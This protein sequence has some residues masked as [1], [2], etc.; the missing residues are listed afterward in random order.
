MNI[1]TLEPYNML[2]AWT[3]LTEPSQFWGSTQVK[4]GGRVFD[5]VR[6]ESGYASITRHRG[7]PSRQCLCPVGGIVL[8]SLASGGLISAF[9]ETL[10]EAEE[11]TGLAWMGLMHRFADDRWT[12]A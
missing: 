10:D 2:M 8:R 11:G 4:R 12:S 7:D 1:L 6:R 3:S 9:A 5:V